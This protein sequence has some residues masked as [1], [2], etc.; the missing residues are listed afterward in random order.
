MKG[1]AN[2]A[3]ILILSQIVL[4]ACAT[5]VTADDQ[6]GFLSDHSRLE[7]VDDD[8]L[9]YTSGAD[10]NYSSFIVDPV[11]IAF[12][13]AAVL[14]GRRAFDMPWTLAALFLCEQCDSLPNKFAPPFPWNLREHRCFPSVITDEQHGSHI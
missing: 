6:S 10:G 2:V 9:R 13:Q 14:A 5:P 12:R 3:L 4:C 8:I 11:V 7:R 1:E